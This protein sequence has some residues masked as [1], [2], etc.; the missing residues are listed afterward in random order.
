MDKQNYKWVVYFIGI[1][2]LLTIAAQVYWNYREYQ[3]NKGNLIS[4]VQLSLDNAVEAYFVNLTKS[5]IITFTSVD[6]IGENK[7]TDTIIV[8]TIENPSIFNT[9]GNTNQTKGKVTQFNI[10]IVFKA[11][12]SLKYPKNK[13]PTSISNIRVIIKALKISPTIPLNKKLVVS[14]TL[15]IPLSNVALNI[16][17]E[18]FG[19]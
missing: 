12:L 4:K 10:S 7:K 18:P 2:V 19:L 9:K 17:F 6:S 5:G 11:F 3:I 14:F 8:K 16:G 15:I 1:T 13:N